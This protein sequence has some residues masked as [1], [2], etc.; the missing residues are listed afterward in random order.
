MPRY[1]NTWDVVVIHL[2]GSGE[3]PLQSFLKKLVTLLTLANASC[4]SD[5]HALDLQC[6]FSE[7]GVLHIPTKMRRSGPPKMTYFTVGTG[8][9]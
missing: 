7:E 6:Q 9:K 1:Q 5:L 8:A 4:A 2:K 3:Q